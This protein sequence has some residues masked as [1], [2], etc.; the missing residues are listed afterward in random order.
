MVDSA[1][2]PR[3][4]YGSKGFCELHGGSVCFLC[5]H[6]TML[7]VSDEV[8]RICGVGFHNDGF[9]NKRVCLFGGYTCPVK[10]FCLPIDACLSLPICQNAGTKKGR[11]LLPKIL[12][13]LILLR[14]T[15][16][17]WE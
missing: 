11:S 14:G 8:Q 2:V 5:M 16:A 15:F 7:H 1:A 10:S 12:E 17:C 13:G 4:V 9:S 3:H 6:S